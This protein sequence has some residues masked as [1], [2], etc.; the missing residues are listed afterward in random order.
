VGPNKPSV[1]F[2]LDI[3]I[4]LIIQSLSIILSYG[5]FSVPELLCEPDENV[6]YT[7]YQT[8][9]ASKMPPSD[10]MYDK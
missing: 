5:L 9:K 2:F 6:P 8:E 7:L 1:Y 4:I 10:D 3:K